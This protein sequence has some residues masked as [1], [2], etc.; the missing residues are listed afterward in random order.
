MEKLNIKH[1]HGRLDAPAFKRANKNDL[2]TFLK[3]EK[4][5]FGYGATVALLVFEIQ[6]TISVLGTYG[7]FPVALFLIAFVAVV[8]M[9]L[10]DVAERLRENGIIIR[11][12][13][14]ALISYKEMAGI[15]NPIILGQ[16]RFENVLALPNYFVGDNLSILRQFYKD[17]RKNFAI[18][19]IVLYNSGNAEFYPK[20]TAQG[21]R[22]VDVSNA[23]KLSMVMK[24]LGEIATEQ[25]TESPYIYILVEDIYALADNW[26]DLRKIVEGFNNGIRM[27]YGGEGELADDNLFLLE[28]DSGTKTLV[29]SKMSP[30][31]TTENSAVAV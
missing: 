17:N 14:N 30:E 4:A 21:F 27:M 6:S 8:G 18:Q 9:F 2:F 16:E 1:I 23:E 22:P 20:C 25:H 5:M 29:S 11:R 19:F 13:G 15:K 10:Y 24:K 26:L 28:C 12:F 7:K 3:R 31:T